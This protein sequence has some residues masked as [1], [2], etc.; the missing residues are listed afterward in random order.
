MKKQQKHIAM[1]NYFKNSKSLVQV[2]L[3]TFLAASMF[4]FS[5]NRENPDTIASKEE[6]TGIDQMESD[7]VGDESSSIADAAARGASFNGRFANSSEILNG[8]ATVTRD[9]LSNNQVRITVDFG[10][11][12]CLGGDGRNR[13]GKII[14]LVTGNYFE[15][16]SSHVITYDNY[17][18]NDNKI[19]GTRT[20][21]NRGLNGSNQYYWTVEAREMKVTRTDGKFHSW[22]SDRVRTMLNGYETAEISDD[23]YQITGTGSGINSNNVSY[24]AEITT[25]LH[26]IMSCRFIDKGIIEFENSNGG[27]RKIDFGNGNCDNQATVE[28][29][30]RRG[31]VITRTITLR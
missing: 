17:Y 4:I 11:T 3:L 19:E 24:T 13:R 31:R 22:N 27:K 26:R 10:A 30:G 9:T 29:T 28:V 2:K 20:I 5:C 7:A 8:C 25:P 12:N 14:I 1:K 15:Q 21:T 6:T 18:R 23:E 16:G